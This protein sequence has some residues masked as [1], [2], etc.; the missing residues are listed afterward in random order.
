MTTF[1]NLGNKSPAD[2]FDG[3]PAAAPKA[4]GLNL[5]A[6]LKSN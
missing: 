2:G 1:V 4:A 6:L 3:A 5:A